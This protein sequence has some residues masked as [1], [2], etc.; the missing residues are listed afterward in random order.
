MTNY[1]HNATIAEFVKKQRTIHDLRCTI[2]KKDEELKEKAQLQDKITNL[3]DR[4][5][6][7]DEL[8]C[9]KETLM[10]QTETL[11]RKVKGFHSTIHVYVSF[12]SVTFWIFIL[13]DD[14]SVGC[15]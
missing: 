5:K 13:S 6:E 14:H 4:L 10:M 7:I 11:E 9:Q 1:E 3:E 2:E 15:F 8:K 12:L